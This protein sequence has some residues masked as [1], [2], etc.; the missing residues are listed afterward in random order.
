MRLAKTVSILCLMITGATMAHAQNADIIKQRREEMRIIAKAGVPPFRMTRD[1]VPF[2]LAA[3]QAYVKVVEDHAPKFKAMFPPD[4]KTGAT[5]ATAKVWESP[6][7]FNAALD[8]YVATVRAASAAVKDEASLKVEYPKIV[9][10]CGACHGRR[11]G[12]APGLSE[13]FKRMEEPL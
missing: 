6:A 10:G 12:F 7:E 4:S 2:D 8:N 9:E 5:S 1:Q 3:F 11:G 13:S